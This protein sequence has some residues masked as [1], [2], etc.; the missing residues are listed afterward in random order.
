MRLRQR[1]LLLSYHCYGR[2]VPAFLRQYFSSAKPL[3]FQMQIQPPSFATSSTVLSPELEEVVYKNNLELGRLGSRGK[4]NEATK[5]FDE[6]PLRDIV[7]YASM[8]S[9]YLK[10]N[11]LHKAESLYYT[12]PGRSIVA[13]SAMVHAYAKTGRLEIARTIFNRMPMKNVFSW[14]GLISGY[15]Q[16]GRVDEACQLFQQ[17]PEKNVVSWTTMLVGFA[18]NGFID[19][20]R[21]TFDLMPAKNAVAWTAMI[22]AYV[23]NGQI[24]RALQLFHQMP[25]RNI[26]SWNTVIQACL[27]NDKVNEALRLFNSMPW[28]NAVSWTIMV[29]G[30]ARNGLTDVAR[31]Y[32]NQM[33]GKDTIAWNAM[34]AA[35]ADEGLMDKASELFSMMPERNTATWNT[36]IDG[37][38][39]VGPQSQAIRHFVFMLHNS[40]RPNVITLTSVVTSCEGIVELLQAHGFVIRLG[41]DQETSLTNALITMYSKVGDVA[42]ARIAF[43]KL[44]AKDVISWT[45][46]ILA[47]SN[48][49]FGNQALQTFARMLRSGNEPDE[50]TFTG[51]LSACSHAGL[52]KKGQRLFDSMRHAYGINPKAE[53][54]CC[55]VD[56]L[57]RGGLVDEAMRVV[58]QIPTGECDAAVLGALLSS[59][60]LHG[61]VVLANLIGEKL[62]EL[63]PSNSGSYVLLANSYAACGM[64]D[65]FAYIRRKMNERKVKKVGGFSQVQVKGKSHV[66]FAGDKSHPELKDIYMLLQ[67]KLL[68]VM[69]D[70]NQTCGNCD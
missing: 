46:V 62:L 38:A 24:D 31:E 11:D 32:F 20:A 22:R 17:M 55:L 40:H 28:R 48:H 60:K 61:E 10:N 50:L 43:E 30:L 23:E 12:M 68:P 16:N 70:A 66:F 63:E 35:Y 6:M 21:E 5:L 4:V 26:Y 8:I 39:K 36:L 7:S 59:C 44:E 57:G 56:I 52:V 41:L 49:G 14:T 1:S 18:R 58:C 34:I 9:I 29:T 54:Y 13:D 3:F 69:Q 53:H 15:F 42:S 2:G 37:Y 27:D 25:Q 67:E 33:P 51:I 45:A 47:Y 65:K 64:W 19:K